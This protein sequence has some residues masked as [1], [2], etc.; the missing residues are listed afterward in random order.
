MTSTRGINDVAIY[1]QTGGYP[2]SLSVTVTLIDGSNNYTLYSGS[3]GLTNGAGSATVSM[4]NM[5]VSTQAYVSVAA[6]GGGQATTGSGYQIWLAGNYTLT[7]SASTKVVSGTTYYVSSASITFTVDNYLSGIVADASV[8]Y[9]NVAS[10]TTLSLSGGSGGSGTYT[11]QWRINGVNQSGATSSTYSFTPTSS[12]V[13]INIFDCIVTDTAYNNN[14]TYSSE[15]IVTVYTAAT[16]TMS[17]SSAFVDVGQPLEANVVMTG[18]SGY[19]TF[20]WYAA[21]TSGGA[22]SEVGTGS[23]LLYYPTTVETLYFYAVVQ[24]IKVSGY[25]WSGQSSPK[26]VSFSN[27]MALTVSPTSATIL[28]TGS[29]GITSVNL[30]VTVA[31]GSGTYNYQWYD[32]N[33]KSGTET[34]DTTATTNTLSYGSSAGGVHSIYCQVTDFNTSAVVISPVIEVTILGG[35]TLT[36]TPTAI[37]LAVGQLYNAT[38]SVN[39]GSGNY[40]YEW[41]KS[42]TSTKPASGTDDVGVNSPS[43]SEYESTSGTFYYFCTVTDNVTTL[44]AYTNSVVTVDSGFTVSLTSTYATVPLGVSITAQLSINGTGTF[45]VVWYDNNVNVQSGSYSTY[46]SYTLTESTTQTHVIQVQVMSVNTGIIINSNSLTLVW[47]AFTATISVSPQTVAVGQSF[48][49]TTLV[50]GGSGSYTYSWVSIS[51]L[52]YSS[53]TA[54]NPTASASAVGTY[55]INVTVTD[56]VFN[57]AVTSNTIGVNVNNNLNVNISATSTSVAVGQSYGLTASAGGGTGSY[58]YQWYVNGSAISGATSN[59]LL[60]SEN[61]AGS[62]AYYCQVKSGGVS[63]NSNTITVVVNSGGFGISLSISPQ[64]INIGGQ[65]TLTA[66]PLNSSGTVTYTYWQTGNTTPLLSNTTSTTYTI[67]TPLTSTSGQYQFYVSA[68]NGTNTAQSNIVT[69]YVGT[70][71]SL[72]D[73]YSLTES[74]SLQYFAGGINKKNTGTITSSDN[75]TIRDNGNIITAFNINMT[76]S[77]GIAGILQF[78]IPVKSGIQSP[79]AVGDKIEMGYLGVQVFLGYVQD[80]KKKSTMQYDITAYDSLYDLGQVT[81]SYYPRSLNKSISNIIG[82]YVNSTNLGSAI[83]GTEITQEVGVDFYKQPVLDKLIQ[84]A[85]SYNHHIVNDSLNNIHLLSAG[86]SIRDI[87]ENSNGMVVLNKTFNSQ[88]LYNQFVV[89]AV[90]TATGAVVNSTAGVGTTQKVVGKNWL[91]ISAGDYTGGVLSTM[92][93]NLLPQYEN[94]V[95]IVKIFSNWANP[96]Y[97][98][99]LEDVDA[100]GKLYTYTITF[101]DG[102]TLSDMILTDIN[103]SN[104]GVVWTFRTAE[105][106]W[107]NSLATMLEAGTS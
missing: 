39:G 104:Q 88:E 58:S 55:N 29:S 47:Q 41:Q 84:L 96:S 40:K 95:W 105:D 51:N 52:S 85:L 80:V 94:G 45:N 56:T 46:P 31:G 27:P 106:S 71:V 13:G 24:D 79:I 99:K 16:G 8:A 68:A 12:N 7:I 5:Y 2:S 101:A 28:A 107:L 87:T 4:S 66:T 19:F 97:Q 21:T 48:S 72:T 23:V 53:N 42:T 17:V 78:S 103:Y 70:E 26:E 81:G 64:G 67:T 60:T 34:S 86:T 35:L 32:N 83:T 76:R 59:S 49:L 69:L 73:S 102:T 89:E 57:K 18:G 22:G 43:Y 9:L 61:T 93:S 74:F 25:S 10:T 92:A 63:A 36:L 37:T 50:S 98:Y 54:A 82:S 20:V 15:V 77:F 1:S 75:F 65:A 44:S 38:M 91:Y 62:Y 11:Y 100:N 30:T 90:D 6:S 33:A 14:M 3:I